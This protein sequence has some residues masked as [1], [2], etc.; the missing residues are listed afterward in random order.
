MTLSLLGIGLTGA[1][2]TAYA[3][4]TRPDWSASVVSRW[5]SLTE[6]LGLSGSKRNDYSHL[7]TEVA[8]KKPF[9]ISV[10]VAGHVDSSGN[11]TLTSLVEGST[12]IIS[13]VAEGTAVKT[14]DVVCELDS[15]ALREK[16]T[17]QEIK[18]SQAAAAAVTAE[19]SLEIL[20]RQNETDIEAVKLKL[21]L[22]DLDLDKFENGEYPKSVNQLAGNVAIA[23]EDLLRIKETYEFTKLQVRKGA[24]TQNDL[25]AERIGV[26]Q[27]E[28][29]LA[30]AVEELKVLKE[31]DYNRRIEELKA[32]AQEFKRELERT[33]IKCDAAVVQAKEDI[34]AKTLTAEA[35]KSTL[36][37]WK[38]Q[39]DV[40]TMRAPQD[41]EVVYANLQNSNRGGSNPETITEG[42]QVRERQAIIN[43]PDITR[44]KVDCRIHESQIAAVR[45]DLPTR[46][47]I[48]AFPDTFFNGVVTEVSSV[49]MSGR[50]PQ[51][52]LRE[53]E[54]EI[55]LTD[56]VEIL[57]TLRPGLT[58][59]VEILVDNRDNV[60]QIPVQSVVAIGGR[61]FAFVLTENGPVRRDLMVGSSNQSHVEVKDGVQAG[62]RVVL[63][64]RTR[65]APEIA[66]IEGEV[67]REL[68]K[69][70]SEIKI[71]AG[72]TP[73]GGPGE[74]QAKPG[75]GGA[76]GGPGAPAGPG[77]SS[78]PGPNGSPGERKS[79]KER[80]TAL[81]TNGDGQ[82]TGDELQGPMKDRLTQIDT[83]G[84]G[85]I[86]EAEFTESMARFARN[87]PA[88]AAP[89]A[90][91][92]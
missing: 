9:L 15:S 74:G 4:T 14:G 46:I 79:P 26:K 1:G 31:Y 49:P 43:L 38:R 81:D 25:E 19:K 44:M 59:Q 12:T 18:A 8:E 53:Y 64:P 84:N 55:K 2:A 58:A 80:F 27:A 61:T 78:G 29:K 72:A 3:V 23:E 7:I 87:R 40:C 88:N 17:L 33:Q 70:A 42:A 90:P 57:K 51:M 75:P 82:L 86:S 30:T 76:P 6:N 77:G 83:D 16:Y 92:L 11:A 63:N 68:G 41:G 91:K 45:R 56:G 73:A 52:D 54:T 13:I 37:R 21:R 5:N 60:L 89:A 36:E 69:T 28:L 50:W 39:I 85:T 48:E 35:E 22:A 24:R 71:P 62:E 65:F 32:N 10:N 66:V 34:K 67:A 47:R 20:L